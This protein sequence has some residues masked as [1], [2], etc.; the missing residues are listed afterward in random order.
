MASRAMHRPPHLHRRRHRQGQLGPVRPVLPLPVQEQG[1]VRGRGVLQGSPLSSRSERSS[2]GSRYARRRPSTSDRTCQRPL[3]S[4]HSPKHSIVASGQPRH[5]AM[6]DRC[7]G[8]R[9]SLGAML[10]RRLLLVSHRHGPPAPHPSSRAP[11]QRCTLSSPAPDVH[12][13]ANQWSISAAR[14]LPATREP[15]TQPTVAWVLDAVVGDGR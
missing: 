10:L 3:P 5:S 14:I 4:V 11:H 15:G 6:C 1:Q 13:S 9:A 12:H 8:H 2:L 7:D